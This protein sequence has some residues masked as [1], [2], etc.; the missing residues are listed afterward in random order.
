MLSPDLQRIKH[1]RDYCREIKNTINRYGESFDVFDQDSDYQRSISFSILQI[2][3]LSGGLSLDYRQA[4]ADRIQ[5]GPIKGMRNLVAHNYGSMSREIIWETAV[6]DIP[7]LLQFCEEQL[8]N[9][10]F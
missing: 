9:S 8:S 5:W 7:V 6:V 3:E 2:G 10:E 1:I 4:T